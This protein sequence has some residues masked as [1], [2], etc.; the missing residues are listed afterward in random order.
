MNK[1]LITGGSGQLG[2]CFKAVSDKF[3]S[4]DL[5][6]AGKE[7]VNINDPSTL[8]NIYNKFRFDGI[9][10][11]AAYTNVDNSENDFESAFLINYKSLKNLV[12]F[13]REKK[14]KLIHFSTNYVFDGT[15]KYPYSEEDIPNPINIYGKSKYK[16]EQ[17]I[18]NSNCE[19]V[20]IRISSLFSPYGKN[21]VETIKNQCLS[22]KNLTIVK[23]EW[24]NPTYGI[25]LAKLILKQLSNQY[26]FEYSL[27]HFAN[28]GCTNWFDFA[29]QICKLLNMECKIES[30]LSIDYQSPATR[31]QFGLLDTS[32]IENHLSLSIATWEDALKRSLKNII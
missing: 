24:I 30:C 5:F 22:N 10:N 8:K 3:P 9:I 25:D 2:M 7:I 17:L 26:F 13:C 31:P 6:F 23:D 28:R 4:L 18:K 29:N 16:G 20:I 32:R 19:H 27:Y 1:F 11:C 21:F 14:L 12:S 15:S